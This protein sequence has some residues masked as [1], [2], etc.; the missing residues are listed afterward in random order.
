MSL[1]LEG[2]L[3]M[4]E[5][6][7]CPPKAELLNTGSGQSNCTKM[8]TVY[9]HG[10]FGISSLDIFYYFVPQ[11]ISLLVLLFGLIVKIFLLIEL[12]CFVLFVV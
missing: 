12:S 4:H 3:V 1:L 11:Y 8:G 6:K 2:H 10:G 9:H 5:Q 7:M